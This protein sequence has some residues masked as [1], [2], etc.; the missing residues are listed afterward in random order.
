LEPSV[1]RGDDFVWV[2]GPFEGFGF[3]GVVFFDEAGDGVF[4][5]CDGGEDPM[6]RPSAGEFGEEAFDSVQP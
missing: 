5:I 3:R 4:E 1:S 6:F 2:C